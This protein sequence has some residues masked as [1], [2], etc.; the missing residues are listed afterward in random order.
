MFLL[1]KLENKV[2]PRYE[3]TSHGI[4]LMISN[5]I[6]SGK[7]ESIIC[8]GEKLRFKIC[9]FLVQRL[10]R[11]IHLVAPCASLQNGGRLRGVNP[12]Q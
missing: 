10:G 3:I 2:N 1:I 4:D 9:N 8:I 7:V 6:K 5:G 11:P 12:A